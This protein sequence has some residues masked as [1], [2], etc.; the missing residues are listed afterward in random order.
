MLGSGPTGRE[1]DESLSQGFA[2]VLESTTE[3]NKSDF[4]SSAF[5]PLLSLKRS[6]GQ[7][8][9]VQN[10]SVFRKEKNN[11]LSSERFRKRH[12]LA[13]ASYSKLQRGKK[14][15]AFQ[16][17]DLFSFISHPDYNENCA[18]TTEKWEKPV[19][20]PSEDSTQA[21][22]LRITCRLNIFLQRGVVFMK[23]AAAVGEK[24]TQPTKKKKPRL[25][26]F[27]FGF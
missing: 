1:A 17:S 15:A 10:L 24:T 9:H 22:L 11:V 19:Q 8:S 4:H 25:H 26:T 13:S 21:A 6:V 18:E 16:T 3:E 14:K 7:V 2:R 5:P 20:R 12:S 23:N 27:N